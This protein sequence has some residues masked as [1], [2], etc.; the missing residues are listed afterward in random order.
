MKILFTGGGTGG[1]IYPLMAVIREIRNFYPKTDLELFYIGPKDEFGAVLLHQEE[2]KVYNIM[3][4]KIRNYFSF[5]NII[6]VF[7]IPIG[8]IQSIFLFI[9]I[10]PHL[11]F[12]KGGYGSLPV[13]FCANL[14]KIPIF[15]HESDSVPG[16]SNRIASKWAK[17]IFTSFPK[18]EYFNPEKVIVSGN[19]LRL[20]LLDGDKEK[21]RDMFNLVMTKPV[22]LFTGGSQ[23]AEFIND[24]VLDTINTILLKYEVIHVCGTNNLKQVENESRVILKPELT[25]YYHLYGFLDEGQLKHAYTAADFVICRSGAG[26]I[27]EVAAKGIPSVL[28]PLPIASANHQAKNAYIYAE[29]GAAIVMEQDN[30]KQSFFLERLDHLF[31]NP[32]KLEEMKDQALRFA[33]PQAAKMIART[34]LEYLML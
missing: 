25:E 15:I 34:I 8:I 12:S 33:K 1:H 4:G 26:S 19:P 22:L 31:T 24:F 20:G 29:T 10:E 7:R 3:A 11:V 21:A 5:E 9:K 14:F 6:D 16:R 32:V 2:V 17:K 23:G 28:I 30:L 13:T 18:T 27:F